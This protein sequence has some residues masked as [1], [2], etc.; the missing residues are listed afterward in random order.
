[1]SRRL[2]TTLISAA[3]VMGVLILVLY[4]TLTK[5]V[6]FKGFSLCTASN[7][8]LVLLES[9]LFASAW[10]SGFIV[11]L[12]VVRKSILPHIF[13]SLFI[14][15]KFMIFENCEGFQGILSFESGSNAML[16]AG[17][18]A[19]HLSAVRFPLMPMNG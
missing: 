16:L 14:L 6:F 19:G 7:T 13:V 4:T 18:W 5:S 15:A 1:M 12:M 9:S 11:S 2:Y 10:V 3:T 8:E 17:L